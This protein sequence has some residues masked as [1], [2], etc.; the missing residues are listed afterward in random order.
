[1]KFT[2]V[3]TDLHYSFLE[4]LKKKKLI[5]PSLHPFWVTLCSLVPATEPAKKTNSCTAYLGVTEV[6]LASH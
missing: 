6:S 5:S 1:M 3:Y 4:L 2:L